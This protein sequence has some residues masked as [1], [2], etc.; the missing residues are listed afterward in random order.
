MDRYAVLGVLRIKA[1]QLN[2][3]TTIADA[4]MGVGKEIEILDRLI[5]E[6][7]NEAEYADFILAINTNSPNLENLL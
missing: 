7:L 2:C 3:D 1:R 6:K 4:V 5:K